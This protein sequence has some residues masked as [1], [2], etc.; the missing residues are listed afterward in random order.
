MLVTSIL[1]PVHERYIDLCVCAWFRLGMKMEGRKEGTYEEIHLV[2]DHSGTT[3]KSKS[4]TG[5]KDL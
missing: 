1:P 4:H 2:E 3:D 5:R